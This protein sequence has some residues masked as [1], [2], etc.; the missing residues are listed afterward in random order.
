MFGVEPLAGFEF[1]DAG[2]AEHGTEG[3]SHVVD[4][5][6]GKAFEFSDGLAEF[7]SAFLD[8]ALETDGELL[9]LGNVENG[10]DSSDGAARGPFSVEQCLTPD[11]HPAG[12]PAGDGNGV[13]DF[14]EPVAVRVMAAA[15]GFGRALAVL[16]GNPFQ[17]GGEAQRLMS[18]KAQ[19]L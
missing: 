8:S 18:G 1:Q 17:K 14:D 10:T 19:D 5:T 9:L 11:A 16:R 3:G 12:A 4:K 7:G 6:V 13:F 2:V 15:D